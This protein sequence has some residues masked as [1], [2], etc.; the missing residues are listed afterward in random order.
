M[1]VTWMEGYIGM[2]RAKGY[3]VPRYLDG[4]A[5]VQLNGVR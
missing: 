4:L 2:L 3:T 1:V 5:G